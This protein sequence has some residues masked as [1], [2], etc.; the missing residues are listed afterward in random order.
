MF[1]NGA[2][3]RTGQ[4][5]AGDIVSAD[6]ALVQTIDW[7]SSFNL[8][9]LAVN[10]HNLV[11]ASHDE[12]VAALKSVGQAAVLKLRHFKRSSAKNDGDV[13]I[14]IDRLLILFYFILFLQCQ[15]QQVEVTRQL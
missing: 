6:S 2:A 8:Q 3:D 7:C 13:V 9:I 4:V 14:L 1:A 5:H 10:E 11:D 12:A 15:A